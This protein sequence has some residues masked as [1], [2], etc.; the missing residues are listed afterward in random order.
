[1]HVYV[2][3]CVCERVREKQKCSQR[4]GTRVYVCVSVIVR[5]SEISRNAVSETAHACMG[6]RVCL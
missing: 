2:C 5:E 4:G 6:V 1:M 3:E